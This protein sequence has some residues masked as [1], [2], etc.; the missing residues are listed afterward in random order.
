MAVLLT[1]TILYVGTILIGV[2]R[3]LS[4]SPGDSFL[5]GWAEGGILLAALIAFLTDKIKTGRDYNQIV[6]ERDAERQRTEE[7]EKIAKELLTDKVFPALTET[8]LVLRNVSDAV[9]PALHRMNDR[10]DHAE[11]LFAEVSS[12]LKTGNT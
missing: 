9:L 6:K 3:I 7:A 4:V 11:R 10:L 8:Q 5:P 12:R 2:N 1:G